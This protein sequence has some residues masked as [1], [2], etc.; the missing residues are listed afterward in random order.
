MRTTVE[1]PFILPPGDWAPL[2]D[3]AAPDGIG[4]VAGAS[5]ALTAHSLCCCGS[6]APV[7]IWRVARPGLLEHGKPTIVARSRDPIVREQERAEKVA[8][9]RAA[10]ALRADRAAAA[11]R[12]RAGLLPG[13]RLSGAGRGRTRARL[14][15]RHLDRRDQLRPDRRQPAGKPGRAAARV[16][17]DDLNAALRHAGPASA[18][19]VEGDLRA[20]WVNQVRAWACSLGGAPQFFTPRLLP[21]F[22]HPR[23][24]AEAPS[25]YDTV[26]AAGDA[27]AAGRFRP[28]QRLRPMRLQ[29][30]CG[31]RAHRQLRLF[32]HHDPSHRRR[33]M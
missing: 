16:L 10:P 7:E 22:L 30:R 19:E 13:R 14:G 17:G 3:T 27:R 33:S 24:S 1:I 25:Y 15:R 31:Q 23:G 11:G 12:R 26:A 29:R 2:L 20:D 4:A 28:A 6:P 21:P 18:C 8:S 5:M 9:R 32:Q